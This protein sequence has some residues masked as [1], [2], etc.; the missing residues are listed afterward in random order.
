MHAFDPAA[1]VSID[2]SDISNDATFAQH[3]EGMMQT[4]ER[5]GSLQHTRK[6]LAPISYSARRTCCA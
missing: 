1:P 6:N 5:L 3:V 2:G 4:I